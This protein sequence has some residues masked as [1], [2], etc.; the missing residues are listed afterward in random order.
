M[1]PSG[2]GATAWSVTSLVSD[3]YASDNHGFLISDAVE[4]E[5]GAEEAFHSREKPDD[6]PP[7]LEIT[8]G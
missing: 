8:F 5:T 3:M 1:S 2:T 4:G 6:H 7:R